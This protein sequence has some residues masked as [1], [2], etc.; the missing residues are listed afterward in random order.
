MSSRKPP[1]QGFFDF[2][3]PQ[4]APGNPV[5]K[6]LPV[7][8]DL[9]AP[10]PATP[11]DD[12]EPKTWTVSE[13]VRAAARTL[14]SRYGLVWVEGEVSN[15]SLPRSGHVYFTL[16][17]A[18][19]QLPA[20]MFRSD[21]QRLKFRISDG[22]KL[23][24]RGRLTI[25]EGQ[26][27][28]QLYADALEPAGLGALQL[29]FEQLKEKLSKEG[30]FDAARKRPLPRWPKRIGLVTSPTGAAVR[31]VVR[32]AQRRGRVKILISPCQ[33]QGDGAAATVIFALK[34]LER[35]PDVDVIIVARGGGS[36]EDLAS[37]NDEA[38]ARAIA[39]CRV[40]VVSAVGHEVD[41]T[42]ADFVADARA[43]TPSHAAELVV[44]PFDE[45]AA[46]IAELEQRLVRAGRRKLAEA[47]QRLDVEIDKAASCVRLSLSKRRRSLD[48]GSRR[49]AS[50]HPRA[51]LARDRAELASLRARMHARI[52]AV[53]DQRR[54]G[55]HTAVGKL[56]ALSPLGVLQRG[57]SL[58]RDAGGHVL[59]D[60][61]NAREGDT[62]NVTLSRGELGCR[63]ESVKK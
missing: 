12:L 8:P 56:D 53:V 22:L 63:V 4:R 45:A 58:T 21:A 52:R 38:L 20:V 25:Y 33:V 3:Q 16:K 1:S 35:R 34:R 23:R 36:A 17:D 29:A 46:R 55:F 13:L 2:V 27:K 57:Y 5:E 44:P 15:L 54:R 31:D 49:L 7:D 42:I 40:P 30:L 39:A 47:R 18:D 59:T 19:A 37:F 51:R 28:F 10:P 43:A 26:G 48:E 32:I 14:E 9:P 6:A 62:V 61:A 60:A 11:K 24:A 50:L 41:F